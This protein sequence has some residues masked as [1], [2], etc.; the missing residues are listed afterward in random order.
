VAF[1]AGALLALPLGAGAQPEPPAPGLAEAAC[2]ACR[3]LVEGLRR[4]LPRA[5][6]EAL[7]SGEIV[8]REPAEGAEE[9]HA[10][11]FV[12]GRRRGSALRRGPR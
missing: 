10:G 9:A 1:A 11:G 4:D 5:D 3:A 7:L 6:W 2:L 12:S 8:T